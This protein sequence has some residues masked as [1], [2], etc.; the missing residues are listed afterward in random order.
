MVFHGSAIA[1]ID[2][3]FGFPRL[4][5]MEEAIGVGNVG[6]DIFLFLSGISLFFSFCKNPSIKAFYCKRIVRLAVPVWVIDGVY[7][8]FKYIILPQGG[9]NVES[10]V[11][12]MAMMQFW[13]SGDA[14]IWFVSFILFLYIA[15]PFIYK[16][17]YQN[18]YLCK[19][20]S[21][22]VIIAMAY[23][24][25]L[26]V[27]VL[28]PEWYSNVEIALTRIP[29]FVMGC[30]FG[31]AVHEGRKTSWALPISFAFI[32]I[33]FLMVTWGPNATSKMPLRFIYGFEGMALSFLFALIFD[34]ASKRIS[35]WRSNPFNR[36]LV[37]AGGASLELYVAHIAINQ[38]LRTHSWYSHHLVWSYACV[39]VLSFAIAVVV[40]KISKAASKRVA[41]IVDGVR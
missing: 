18:K 9:P 1:G 6:V 5:F 24:V 12:R 7:W 2:F 25:P 37:F 14:T 31:E 27:S 13:I 11:N 23:A 32:A 39:V 36:M 26:L 40:E 30:C 28:A 21:M 34:F 4:K 20:L 33:L 38:I 15:F 8:L 17:V 41:R 10:F 35:S 16:F 19:P 3:S 22:A 29:V